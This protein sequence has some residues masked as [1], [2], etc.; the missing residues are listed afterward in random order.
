[1]RGNE[2]LRFD[3][4]GCNAALAEAKRGGLNTSM[5]RVREGAER[6]CVCMPATG[7]RGD[8]QRPMTR[9]TKGRLNRKGADSKTKGDNRKHTILSFKCSIRLQQGTDPSEGRL[10]S[11]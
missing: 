9:A 2:G 1:M 7:P 3:C 4:L 11:S 10:A 6:E 8:I 5:L